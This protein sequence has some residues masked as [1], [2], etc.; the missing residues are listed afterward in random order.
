[1]L[2]VRRQKGIAALIITITILMV[3]T[4]ITL[5]TARVIVTDNKI[6]NNVKNNADALNAAQA[7]FNY[8]L[9]YLNA[10]PY[11][12]LNGLA[13]CS[14]AT[15]T[16]AL[17]AGTLANNS[18]YTMTFSCI[19]AGS[20][21]S[22]NLVAVGT[23]EDA[24]S[25]R[26][27]RATLK[28]Y[29]G[30]PG[31]DLVARSTAA[32]S[33]TAVVSNTTTSAV[34]T[35]DT[36]STTTLSNTATSTTATGGAYSCAVGQ[37]APT[38]C[39]NIRSSTFATPVTTALTTAGGMTDANFQTLYLGRLISA[40]STLATVNNINCT[41][42]SSS[43]TAATT[44]ASQG[45]TNSGT[46]GTGAL[47]A[48]TGIIYITIANRNLTLTTTNGGVFTLGSAA[49]PALLVVNATTGNLTITTPNPAGSAMT[50]NGNV[51][52]SGSGTF[53]LN[54]G[55]NGATTVNGMAF[56]LGAGSVLNGAALVGP[57]IAN[58]I[59]V[60]NASTVSYNAAAELNIS[61][62]VGGFCGGA[63]AP[64]SGSWRDF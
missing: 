25:A 52:Y 39:R 14:A 26:T 15:N 44:L 11:V 32:L 55:S 57:F 2:S 24:S 46:G 50:V 1:L 59:A 16:F 36:G 38:N 7:G 31:I 8:A 13:Y 49:T 61:N 56:S 27:I 30:G 17:T 62:T 42:G 64:V 63:Y 5:F 60:S 54:E 51:Y 18:T 3:V 41:G 58:S 40:F 28:Q 9:G 37:T 48:M 10:Y 6:Y 47:S 43:F 21:T 33:N 12:V 22:I 35:I 34:R 4:I 29:C 45:C 20:F 23:S 19:T 53:S